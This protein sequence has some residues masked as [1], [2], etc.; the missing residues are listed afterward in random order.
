M[1]ACLT[2]LAAV[3]WLVSAALWGWASRRPP[4]LPRLTADADVDWEK[5][6]NDALKRGSGRNTY[7]AWAAMVAAALQGVALFLH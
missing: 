4:S 1:K 3:A 2:V 5:P 6:L 7:A